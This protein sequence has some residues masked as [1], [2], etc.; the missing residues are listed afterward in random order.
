MEG[1]AAD[2]EQRASNLR[3]TILAAKGSAEALTVSA[4]LC[5]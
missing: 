5:S 2:K 1:V 3:C 4:V